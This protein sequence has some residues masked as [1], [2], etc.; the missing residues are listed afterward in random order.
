[1]KK[2]D[3]SFRKT[4]T[5]VELFVV[6]AVSTLGLAMLVT[7]SEGAQADAR[8][9]SCR[10]ILKRYG[11]AFA[12]YAGNYN[13]YLPA[14]FTPNSSRT[15]RWESAILNDLGSKFVRCPANTPP[16]TG[17]GANY[18]YSVTR[19]AKLPFHF[20][21]PDAPEKSKLS[22]YSKQL[23]QIVLIGDG[24]NYICVSPIQPGCWPVRDVSCDGIE[25]SARDADYNYYDPQRHDGFWNYVSADGSARSISFAEWQ[26]NLTSSGIF[27]NTKYNF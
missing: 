10:N 11:E 23:P 7:A 27:Y 12:S 24:T 14:G 20:F 15:M 8:S 18:C 16:S 13:D 25:D 3:A 17:Y 4:F 9:V 6:T 19:N 22:K 21:D 2:A 26:D 5:L 1:M